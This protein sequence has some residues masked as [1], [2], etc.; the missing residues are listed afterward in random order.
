[1][2]A[3]LILSIQ[4]Y[5][6]FF[7]F[8]HL[9]YN[10][11]ADLWLYHNEIIHC[12]IINIW[13]LRNN[14]STNWNSFVCI[15]RTTLIIKMVMFICLHASLILDSNMSICWLII[16]EFKLK[17]WCN[18]SDSLECKIVQW[19][20][21]MKMKM[22]MKHWL[23]SFVGIFHSSQI[24]CAQHTLKAISIAQNCQPHIAITTP[25]FRPICISMCELC[26]HMPSVNLNYVSNGKQKLI[27]LQK[28]HSL[29]H[30]KYITIYSETY[31][32]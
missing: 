17:Y 5:R 20:V 6:N 25:Y 18:S 15:E 3:F 16:K 27:C 29:C 31:R 14:I 13:L 24:A 8:E 21:R 11:V 2:I 7:T 28:F 26:T 32:R 30:L 12:L 9:I 23:K 4:Y 22:E 1:M 19:S 10:L